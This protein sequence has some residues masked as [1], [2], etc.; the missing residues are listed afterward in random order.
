MAVAID[1][2]P[3][4]AGAS[5]NGGTTLNY[6]GLTMGTGVSNPALVALIS[7]DNTGSPTISS[8][9]WDATGTP[10]TLTLIAGTLATNGNNS[11]ALYGR[12]GTITAGA[13]TLRVVFSA[14]T[15][16]YLAS[17]SFSGVNQTGGATSFPHGTTATG[18]STSASTGAITSAIGNAV[19]GVGCDSSAGTTVTPSN[20]T[21]YE[22]HTGATV[23]GW[24]NEAAGASTVTLTC[25]LSPTTVWCYS[26]TDVAAAGAAQTPLN[27]NFLSGL[28]SVR[29]APEIDRTWSWSQ[30]RMLGLD[31]LPKRRS[32]QECDPVL[33]LPRSPQDTQSWT[34]RQTG[35]LGKDR[36]PNRQQDWPIPPAPPN[37]DHGWAW[38]QVDK[39]GKD[40]LPF[41]Q[42]DWPNPLPPSLVDANWTRGFEPL[43]SG[44]IQAP[45]DQNAYYD[46]PTYPPFIDQTWVWRQVGML[47]QDKLPFRQQDWPNPTPTISVQTWTWR[48]TGMLGRD[49]LPFR[50]QDWPN[51]IGP[52]RPL[53]QN[54]YRPLSGVTVS[55][56]LPFT[57]YDWPNPVRPPGIDQT[58]TQGF[59]ALRPP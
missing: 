30:T 48:Q 7:W 36:L 46:R 56:Q 49:V 8:V 31:K 41:R 5:L 12:V 34:W 11:S 13:K 18:S 39:L 22:N 9:N 37:I 53:I 21:V 40:T 24:G 17:I 4:G 42:Q 1:A 32:M 47:G 57:Q 52:L 54:L 55:A 35:M 51:P 10:Q 23:N 14:S 29:S 38:R 15:N 44:P 2:N 3:G 45:L 19:V 59:Q 16:A 27:K 50:Q 25:A 43:R 6:T 58:W 33:P 26:G 28:P 20:T